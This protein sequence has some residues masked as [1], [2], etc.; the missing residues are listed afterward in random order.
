MREGEKD[1]DKGMSRRRRNYRCSVNPRRL[2]ISRHDP[3]PARYFHHRQT[4]LTAAASRWTVR[5]MCRDW[6]SDHLP[7]LL[8]STV[9]PCPLPSAPVS[10]LDFVVCTGRHWGSEMTGLVNPLTP[11]PSLCKMRPSD[12]GQFFLG[13]SIKLLESIDKTA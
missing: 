3:I 13:E 7:R 8:D 9:R 12:G 1:V 4:S 10:W 6:L 11:D 2:V 5:W